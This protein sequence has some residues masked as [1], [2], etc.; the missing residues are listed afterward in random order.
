MHIERGRP[1]VIATMERPC[2]GVIVMRQCGPQHHL[3]REEKRGT[4][5]SGL[6]RRTCLRFYGLNKL[7]G[8]GG[9]LSSPQEDVQ[10]RYCE[11]SVSPVPDWIWPLICQLAHNHGIT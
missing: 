1:G 9:A 2:S 8:R 7:R 11:I 3:G 10:K 5:S 4:C 6:V